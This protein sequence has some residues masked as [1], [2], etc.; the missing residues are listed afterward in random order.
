[1][2]FSFIKNILFKKKLKEIDFDLNFSR[3]VRK[4]LIIFF[5]LIFKFEI[6]DSIIKNLEP[7][8]I[9]LANHSNW[10]DPFFIGLFI[11]KP[12][13]FVATEDIFRLFPYNF[14]LPKLGAIPKIKFYPD[15]DTV[16]KIYKV[17]ENKG[18]I[19]IFP[20]GERNWDGA[21]LN[22]VPSTIKLIKKLSLPVVICL[23]KGAHMVYP[24]WAKNYR[25]G[26]IKIEFVHI[27]TKSDIELLDEDKLYKEINEKF[28]YNE[29]EYF[30]GKNI[31]FKGTKKAKGLGNFL[32]ICPHCHSINKNKSR[33]NFFYCSNCKYEV[34]INK[35]N[36]FE[37]SKFSKIN[38]LYFD[39]PYDWNKWQIEFIKIDFI[40]DKTLNYFF[41]DQPV[42]LFSR[43][44]KGNLFK[45]NSGKLKLDRNIFAIH[46]LLGKD[47]IF[48]IDKINSINVLYRNILDFYYDGK[49][50]RIIF[51]NNKISA[52]KYVLT[53]KALKNIL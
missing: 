47:I 12:L 3:F 35:Y 43:K 23:M 2:N 46:T 53:I 42:I 32:F 24:R 9:I 30:R 40:N 26:T 48:E 39:N 27:F 20:E 19:G 5:S 45:I 37:I 34:Y 33:G 50:Y 28:S 44:K 6:N 21:T 8:F 41:K 15:F 13:H 17:K 36:F 7:P 10:W 25:K 51:E 38:K 49:F 31:I 29:Y 52:Y 11:D 16:R 18:I 4:I 22:I 1:M 14:I